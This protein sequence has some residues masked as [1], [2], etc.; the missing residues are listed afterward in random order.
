MNSDQPPKLR[1]APAEPV[2]A[3]THR[4]ERE[5]RAANLQRETEL[6]QSLAPFRVGSVAYLNAVPLTRGLEDQIVL[7]TPAELAGMLSRDELEAALVSVVEV[8]FTDRYDILDGIAIAS[9]GEVKSVILAHRK[10]LEEAREI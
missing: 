3:L 9:L 5:Q 8:L 1:M 7:A 4:V 10:P 2:E 6:E